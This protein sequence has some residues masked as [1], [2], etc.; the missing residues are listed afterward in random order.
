ME[1]DLIGIGYTLDHPNIG[2]AIHDLPVHPAIPSFTH[3]RRGIHELPPPVV[4][5]EIIQPRDPHRYRPEKDIGSA[6]RCKRIGHK[7]V[8]PCTEDLDKNIRSSLTTIFI[9]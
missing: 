9:G 7:D 1:N 5:P 8:R 2:P 6:S 4:H 3:R